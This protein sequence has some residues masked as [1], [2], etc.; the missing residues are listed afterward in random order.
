MTNE[1]AL[2]PYHY[3]LCGLDNIY[4]LNGY[5]I[6]ATEYGETIAI[7]DADGLH[8]A[9]GKWI[10][11]HASRLDGRQ[12]RFLRKEMGYSQAQMAQMMAVDDQTVAN[13][14]KEKS[15]S[16]PA[17]RLMRVL[18]NAR[19][20]DAKHIY[21]LWEAVTHME[22]RGDAESALRFC[23]RDHQWQAAA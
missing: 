22:D 4:L 13:W 14:E 1:L 3:T 20:G 18:Y 10:V 5:R 2:V 6:E 17:D 23:K 19:V 11:R 12:F 8:R 21:E 9:I 7:E 16:G 15:Q